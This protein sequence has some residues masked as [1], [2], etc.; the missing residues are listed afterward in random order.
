MMTDM[1]KIALQETCIHDGEKTHWFYQ[2]AF[3]KEYQVF[4]CVK[5]LMDIW[6][7]VDIK[8]MSD[9]QKILHEIENRLWIIKNRVFDPSMDHLIRC[10]LLTKGN[11]LKDLEEW[12]RENCIGEQC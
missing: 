5:C 8:K 10:E 9:K 11:E 4:K 7:Q 1:G 3:D 2:K 6:E 12:I